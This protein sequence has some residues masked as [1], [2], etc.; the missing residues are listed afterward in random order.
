[1][2]FQLKL[3]GALA[4]TLVAAA[5]FSAAPVGAAGYDT[6]YAFGDSLTDNGNLYALTGPGGPIPAPYPIPP[7]PYYEGR[8]TNGQVWVEY[9]TDAAHLDTALADYA[10]AGAYTG[11]QG[12]MPGTGGTVLLPTGVL[13]PM[14]VGGL[15]ASPGPIFDS[16]DLIT[17]WAGANDYVFGLGGGMIDPANPGAFIGGVV[18]NIGTAVTTLYG[19]GGETFL[20]LNLPDLGTTPEGAASG[21]APILTGLSV[22]HNQ[23]L[24]ASMAALRDETGSDIIVVDVYA[25][26][27]EILAHPDRYGF[28]NTSDSCLDN[29][30][31][32]VCNAGNWDTWLSWD[33]FHPTTAAHEIIAEFTLATLNSAVIGAHT[34]PSLVA[35][36]RR[37]SKAQSK[38]VEHRLELA[39]L[40][41]S[42]FGLL[43]DGFGETGMLDRRL[44]LAGKDAGMAVPGAGSA[45]GSDGSTVTD[46][47]GRLAVYAYRGNDGGNDAAGGNAMSF[48]YTAETQ[49]LGMDYRLTDKVLVGLAYDRADIDATIAGGTDAALANTGFSLYAAYADGGFHA[50]ATLGMSEDD[51]ASLARS[52]GSRLFPVAMGETAGTTT[53]VDMETGY[54]F[55][56]GAVAFGPVAGLRWSRSEIDGYTEAGA[57]P[58]NLSYGAQSSEI[59]TARLGLLGTATLATA[60]GPLVAE[61]GATW[62]HD[63][64]GGDG[65][66]S[67][68]LPDG[69][70]KSLTGTD[71]A[72]DRLDIT[73]GAAMQLASGLTG[74]AEL[75]SGFDSESNPEHQASLSL[76]LRF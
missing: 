38:A 65:I 50:N 41:V 74:K 47:M 35:V 59:A 6:V 16:G 39:S 20:V 54:T 57:G 40:G 19:L 34:T 30:A 23:A 26:Y 69:Y 64:A 10:I 55:T 1:M 2:T 46:G 14:Q 48:D 53:H 24:S 33:G 72:A 15:A 56:A 66:S 37:A 9:F 4:T 22:A 76:M 31:T 58:L 60:T 29:L 11:G 12:V 8:S 45:L 44:A 36:T 5:T 51:Y 61:F 25:A 18:G 17:I 62:S 43:G 3:R 49:S 68:T 52:T 67:A 27:G 7:W 71:A 73:A 32:G 75:A 13:G 42:G 21:A 70:V 63:V 28:A